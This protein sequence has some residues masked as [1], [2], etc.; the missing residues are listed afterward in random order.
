VSAADGD[1]D[2]LGG[3]SM[4]TIQLVE[5]MNETIASKNAEIEQLKARLKV[6][7]DHYNGD[8]TICHESMKE[9]IGDED[10]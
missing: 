8:A 10:E 1:K 6:V 5:Y 3:N 7:R 2:K 9:A 4:S